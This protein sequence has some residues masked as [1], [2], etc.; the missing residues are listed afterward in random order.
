MPVQSPTVASMMQ[1]TLRKRRDEVGI[2]TEDGRSIT[3]AELQ[4]RVWRLSNTLHEHMGL[5]KGDA[6]GVLADNCVE[7]IELDFACSLLGLVKVPLYV[8]N[9]PKEH[10]YFIGDAGISALFAEGPLL[11][12]LHEAFDD[13]LGPLTN[14][15][16]S[17]GDA[18]EVPGTE[19][20][21]DLLAAASSSTPD[22]PE[23]LPS[24]RYQVRYTAGTTGRAKG[25]ATDHRGMLV[26]SNGN[27]V[28]HGQETAVGPSD[29]IAHVL[30]FSH[31]SAFNIAG[32]SQV[33]AKHLPMRKWDPERFLR[34]V[35]E[36]RV[37]IAL[38]VPSM[39][40]MLV[41][42]A[43]EVARGDVSSLQTAAYGGSPMTEAVLD[44][45]LT[46]FGPIFTQGYG[47]TETPSL[48]AWLTKQE[49]LEGRDSGLLNS[50]G[51]AGPWADLQVL[52]EDGSV[53]K[54]GEIGELCI[55]T[56]S[57]L[58]EYINQPE[59]T[60][61]A[62]RGGWYHSG[63]MT[64]MDE[65]GYIFLKDRKHDVIISGG[66]NVYP[67]EVEN[68]IM[69]HPAV[70]ECVVVGSQDD[71]LGETVSAVVRLREG[72]H[73]DLETLQEHCL[74]HLGSYKK[75]RRLVVSPDPLP[76]SEVGKLLRRAVRDWFDEPQTTSADR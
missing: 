43:D 55:R 14:G 8:R 11:G 76:K 17:W 32:H 22:F 48:I 26:A 61:E 69:H 57:A 38:L 53:C 35:E 49:H 62:M 70:V 65:Q 67:A 19:G 1:A 29:V 42:S 36:H 54:P 51:T 24:D 59:A 46:A 20:Y 44:R 72:Q 73:L 50:C 25:A 21:E 27:V 45:A 23:V 68:A 30:P 56:A 39:I 41:E 6:V 74:E 15:V 2:L 13:G 75:P 63:D 12:P 7:Y 37:S 71:R 5:R 9:A 3:Y 16:V 58:T 28:F 64:V 40:G 33:G 4:E 52:D 18:A 34:L 31:A 60:E 47:S 66:F 10:L